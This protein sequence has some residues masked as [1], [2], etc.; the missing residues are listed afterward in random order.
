MSWIVRKNG[1]W[2]ERRQSVDWQTALANQFRERDSSPLTP[3]EVSISTL[4]TGV[5]REHGY[6][7]SEST[8]TNAGNARVLRNI[9]LILAVGCA[10][11]EAN[12]QFHV[13]TA[14]QKVLRRFIIHYSSSFTK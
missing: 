3:E 6:A 10:S 12:R 11:D 1:Q 7:C 5:T 14:G 13:L 4:D 2:Q 8:T 9:R